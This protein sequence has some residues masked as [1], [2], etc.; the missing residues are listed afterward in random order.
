MPGAFAAAISPSV[1]AATTAAR[2]ATVDAVTSGNASISEHDAPHTALHR[3]NAPLPRLYE[4]AGG[5]ESALPGTSRPMPQCL[6]AKDMHVETD[7]AKGGWQKE[8]RGRWWAASSAN[9]RLNV[10]FECTV[11]GC[12]LIVGMTVSSGLQPPSRRP[13][14][15][16]CVKPAAVAARVGGRR[17]ESAQELFLRRVLVW[18]GRIRVVLR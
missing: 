11:D 1:A 3:L 16:R 17:A 10:P 13:E 7:S 18:V 15:R 9:A 5:A 2:P 6:M 4:R 14:P 8:P 12:G